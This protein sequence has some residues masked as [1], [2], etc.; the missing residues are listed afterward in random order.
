MTGVFSFNA[1]RRFDVSAMADDDDYDV[2][3][4]EWVA[5]SRFFV[6]SPWV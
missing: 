4:E 3:G 1:F 5:C 2:L 6:F